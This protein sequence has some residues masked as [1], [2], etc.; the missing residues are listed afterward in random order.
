MAFSVADIA[1]AEAF[2]IAPGDTNYFVMLFDNDS[3]KIDNIFVIEIFKPRP[4]RN[5]HATATNSSRA[6]RR[7]IRCGEGLPIL[8]AVR[9]CCIGLRT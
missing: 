1:K 6:A 2:R 8:G 9:C 3:D 4:R 5:E 7:G